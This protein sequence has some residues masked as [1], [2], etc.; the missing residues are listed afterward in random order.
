MKNVEFT[1]VILAATCGARLY[2]LTTSKDE[3]EIQ[4][5]DENENENETKIVS[6]MPKHLLPLA[7]RPLLHHLLEHC[8]GIGME[9]IVI[10][11]GSDDDVTADSLVGM[12]CIMSNVTLKDNDESPVD[13]AHAHAHAGVVTM[14]PTASNDSTLTTNKGSGVNIDTPAT[15]ACKIVGMKFHGVD[16]CLITLPAEC[17]GSADA[18]RC[19]SS[20]NAISEKSHVMVLPADLVLYGQ[21]SSKDESSGVDALGSL[22]DVHRREYRIGIENG[23]PL[24]MSMLLADVGEEDENGVPLKESAKVRK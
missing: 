21:L 4:D 8:E 11:I 9:K 22:A 2:P 16:I 15:E 23:M 19:I 24:A 13:D 5:E 10:A 20:A 14:T 17:A 12:G 1:A 3:L 6:Y 18:L 7:G